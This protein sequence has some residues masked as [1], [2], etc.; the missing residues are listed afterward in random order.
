MKQHIYTVVLIK[1]EGKKTVPEEVKFNTRSVGWFPDAESAEL[2]VLNNAGDIAEGEY[3]DFVVVEKSPPG[4]YAYNS[5][6]I[7][8]QWFRRDHVQKKW[9]RMNARPKIVTDSKVR[10][11]GIG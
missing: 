3:Y 6:G 11:F 4:H 9:K 5:Y 8:R 7:E 1:L 10:G 2:N